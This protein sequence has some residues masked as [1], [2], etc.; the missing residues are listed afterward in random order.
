MPEPTTIYMIEYVDRDQDN[1]DRWTLQEDSGAHTSERSAQEMADKLNE[2]DRSHWDEAEQ[3]KAKERVKMLARWELLH[4]NGMTAAARPK[5]YVPAPWKPNSGK[6][7][8][9][10]TEIELHD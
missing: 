10:V 3:D 8:Y 2:W 5:E 4:A 9:Q 1:Y 6:G 7:Y